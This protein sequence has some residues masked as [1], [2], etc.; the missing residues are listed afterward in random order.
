VRRETGRWVNKHD[1]RNAL[2]SWV[3]GKKDAYAVLRDLEQRN[4]LST[5]TRGR[6]DEK[7]DIVITPESFRCLECRLVVSSRQEW[8]IHLPDCR[9]QLEK[10]RRLGPIV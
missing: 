5:M 4:C 10:M 9:H 6:D 7:T 1:F 2:D 8:E 3:I